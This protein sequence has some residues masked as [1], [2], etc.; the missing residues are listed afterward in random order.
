M[1]TPNLAD[2]LAEVRAQ[3]ARLQ[4]RELQLQEAIYRAD[5]T[6]APLRPGWPIRRISSNALH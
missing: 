1:Q 3:L 4:Q 6:P 5:G 2:E